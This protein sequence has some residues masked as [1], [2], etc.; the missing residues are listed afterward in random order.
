MKEQKKEVRQEKE[1]EIPFHQV[2]RFWAKSPELAQAQVR[3]SLI[4]R[5][6]QKPAV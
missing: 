2:K 3:G 4:R 6:E 1:K 5:K